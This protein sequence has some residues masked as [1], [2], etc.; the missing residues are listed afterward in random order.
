MALLLP[1][2]AA[3]ALC[4]P[5][6]G[7]L[8][9]LAELRLRAIWLLFVALGLQVVAFPFGFLPWE[10]GETPAKAL[11]LASYA[12]LL[13]AAALNRATRGVPIVAVG[14]LL[15]LA[16]IVANGGQMPVLPGARDASGHSYVSE[17]NSVADP[18]PVLGW[19]VDR[20]AAPDWVPLA[21]VYSVGD[22]VI[23]LGAF[24]LVLAAAG[25]RHLAV[26]PAAAAPR[27]RA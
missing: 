23:A 6:G 9:A 19:L 26:R 2:A 3:L 12:C 10:T 16:A 7:R 24:V 15:N 4:A 21:N 5:L 17:A 20:W 27:V 13:V 25:V 11:W 22:V 8:G 1:I 14:L 18:D